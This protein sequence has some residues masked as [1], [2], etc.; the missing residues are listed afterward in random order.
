MATG[1]ADMTECD[2]SFPLYSMHLMYQIHPM[3]MHS[4]DSDRLL[5][6]VRSRPRLVCVSD[7]LR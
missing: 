7:I 3:Y 6:C 2:G 1:G 5:L 4:V